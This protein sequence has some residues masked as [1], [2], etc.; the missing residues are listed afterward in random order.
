MV[1]TVAAL[2]V[3]CIPPGRCGAVGGAEDAQAEFEDWC[4]DVGIEWNQISIR[5][6][7]IDGL[8]QRGVFAAAPISEGDALLS[9]P[10]TAMMSRRTA[11]DSE[12]GPWLVSSARARDITATNEMALHLLYELVQPS[13]HWRPYLN[14]LPESIPTTLFY[15][16]EEMAEL[17]SSSLV[18]FTRQRRE[19]AKIHFENIVMPL[20]DGGMQQNCLSDDEFSDDEDEEAPLRDATLQQWMWALSILWSRAFSVKI[21]GEDMG[22]LVPFADLFNAQPPGELTARPH[23][24]AEL[25]GSKLIYY[26]VRD[27]AK[28]EEILMPYGK[29]KLHSN[30]QLLMG[31]GFVVEGNPYDTVMVPTNWLQKLKASKK[32]LLERLGTSPSQ[33]FVSVTRAFPLELLWL[34]RIVYFTEEEEDELRKQKK[35]LLGQAHADVAKARLVFDAADRDAWPQFVPFTAHGDLQATEFALRKLGR[36]LKSYPTTS[37]EDERIWVEGTL[38]PRARA[39]LAVR[40]GEKKVLEQAVVHLRRWRDSLA[41]SANLHAT[42][43]IQT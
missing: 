40:L 5:S 33:E 2:V 1:A 17:Q 27:I 34:S 23:V 16:E 8:A 15:T 19:N 24:R 22:A 20:T 12:L 30:A 38:S 7:V 43:H 31:Y 14:V 11:E 36:L 26:A 35:W 39:A 37:T 29:L 4:R 13:S 28:D 21:G 3:A 18:A 10:F 9:I 32:G 25:E 41:S 6:T 42:T